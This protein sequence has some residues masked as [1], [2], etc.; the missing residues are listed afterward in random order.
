[1]CFTG[2]EE[3]TLMK[4]LVEVASDKA[5]WLPFMHKRA[6]KLDAS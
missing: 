2:R 5:C 6:L 3:K 1:M 4:I